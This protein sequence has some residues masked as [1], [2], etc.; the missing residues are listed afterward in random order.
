MSKK[1]QALGS[2]DFDFE[3]SI[4]T[5]NGIPITPSTETPK[6]TPKKSRLEDIKKKFNEIPKEDDKEDLQA[7]K[8]RLEEAHNKASE[9]TPLAE[10]M[11]REKPKKPST[12]KHLKEGYTRHTFAVKDE[13]LELIRAISQYKGIEQKQLL[14][15]LLD[16]A[17]ESIDETTKE[18]AL[19]YLNNDEE[20]NIDIF[21]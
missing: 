14:E 6:E 11:Q 8:K 2:I 21:N 1:K 16:K 19:N 18:E 17:F 12:K 5:I 15:T 10:S 20:R 4:N 13:H 7:L 9:E 3:D